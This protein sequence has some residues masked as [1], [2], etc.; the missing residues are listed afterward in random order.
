M[1][2]PDA[3]MP[4]IFGSRAK[5]FQSM[6]AKTR[7]VISIA[8]L[9]AAM[10]LLSA[11]WRRCT[12][13][14]VSEAGRIESKILNKTMRFSVYLPPGYYVE[15]FRGRK[16][17]VLYI[18]HGA[19]GNH[20]TYPRQAG[21]RK[22][23]DDAI[24]SGRVQ[25]MVVVMPAAVGGIYCSLNRGV[26]PFE[27][28]FWGE[29]VPHIEKTY[30]VFGEKRFRAVAGHSMGGGGALI[31]GLKYPDKFASCCALGAA[32]QINES[33]DNGS[34]VGEN[35]IVTLLHRVAEL[36]KADDDNIVRY[37]IDCGKSDTLRTVNEK[38]HEI[39]DERNIEHEYHEG[40]GGHTWEYWRNG[41]P[42]VL[43][44]ISK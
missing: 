17:P 25:P 24:R 29:L 31:Y 12:E 9:V 33:S 34:P 32:I 21:I 36:R 23:V 40:D 20:T 35:D 30:R 18:F 28:F 39:M 43:E 7:N 11:V 37:Y 19:S 42:G 1:L 38:L 2:M 14:S 8:L 6:K 44:F 26:Y 4:G 15:S 27:E 41:M 22:I 13:S 10:I 16:Y 5:L 3:T